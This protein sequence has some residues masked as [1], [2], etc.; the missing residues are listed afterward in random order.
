MSNSAANAANLS[1]YGG[2]PYL[3]PQQQMQAHHGSMGSGVVDNSGQQSGNGNGGQGRQ[4]S[5]QG[6]NQVHK[7]PA[8]GPNSVGGSVQQQQAYKQSFAWN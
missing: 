8:G 1:S 2:N 4:G 6:G 5:L 7:G 3:L